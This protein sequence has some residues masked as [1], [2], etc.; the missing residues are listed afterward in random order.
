MT[1]AGAMPRRGER[2]DGRHSL[3][4]VGRIESVNE[5]ISGM[6]YGS[7]DDEECA[8]RLRGSPPRVVAGGP[9]EPVYRDRGRAS[10]FGPVKD[11]KNIA[12]TR[13]LG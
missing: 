11:S 12:V 13:Q 9:R 10:G 1:A 5:A 3:V 4:L 2:R 6:P 7:S 8:R